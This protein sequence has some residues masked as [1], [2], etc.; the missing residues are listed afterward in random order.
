[1]RIGFFFCLF[2]TLLSIHAQERCGTVAPS[3]GTFENWISTKIADRN[4]NAKAPAAPLYQIPVVVHVFHKGEQV[5]T[6]V[7]LSDERIKEQIDSLTADFRRMNADAIN[8]PSEFLPVAADIEIEF[9]L[10]KQDPSGNPTN[11]IVR[12]QG[13]RDVY[14]AS[15]H[16]PLLRSESYWP[17]EHYLN[18]YVLDLQ[19]FIGY[20]S[21][22]LIDIDGITNDSDDYAF[23]GV[24]VD[25]E[26]FGVNLSTPT[27][28]S[29]GRT[30]THEVGHWLGL[31]HIWGDGNCAA[32]DFVDDTPLANTDNGDYTSPCTFPNPDDNLV[33]V[34]GEPEMF[35]NY[36]DYTDDICMNLFT[37]GQKTRMRTVMDNAINRI[38]LTTSPGLVGPAKFIDDLA[39]VD[40]ISPEYA[41]CGNSIIPSVR[42]ENHGSTDVTTYD[43]QLFLNGNPNGSAQT[44]TQTLTPQSSDTVIFSAKSISSTPTSIAFEITSVNGGTDTNSGNNTIARDI[45]FTRSV[46]L[47]FSENFEGT[48]KLL[49]PSGVSFPWEVTTAPKNSP[50][51]QAYLFKAFDNT[52]WFGEA[53]VFKTPIFDLTGLPSGD[54]LFSYAHANPTGAFYDGLMV[55]VSLDCGETF[56][57]II[58]S[59]FG[60]NLATAPELDSYFTPANQLEWVDTVLSIT[61]YRDIDGV[62]FAFVGING[63]S[64]NIYIDD[65]QVVETNLFENDIKPTDL[66]GPLI[67]CAEN[68]EL[69]LRI[70]NVGSQNITSFEV[71]YHINGDTSFANFD[72]LNIPS[73]DYS[74]VTINASNISEGDNNVGAEITLVNGVSDES[75]IENSIEIMLN[76]NVLEDEYPLSLDFESQDNWNL[77]SFGEKTLFKRSEISSNGVLKVNGFGVNEL[78]ISSWFISPKLNTGGLDSAGLYFRASYASRDGFNDRLQ[79][80][81]STDCGESYPTVLLDAHS[82]SLAVMTLNE[83]WIPMSDTDWKEYELDLSHSFFFDDNIRIAFVFTPGGGNDLF[84]DDI[85]IRGNS[86]PSY[87]DIAR[88]F[89][90]PAT[91]RFNVGFNLPQKEEVVVKL[92]DI[93]G[94]IVFEDLIENALNQILEY[95]APSQQG[96]YFLNIEGSQF[97]T[98][99]K[100]FINR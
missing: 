63:S 47:P 4:T 69:D 3:T 50:T 16:R 21:F 89:P 85:N 77:T 38:S 60:P 5:G 14:R 34:A 92:I 22:P 98:T 93:S 94:R 74:T 23:D 44:V 43:V 65:I 11:G 6:G 91:S 58:F 70:R 8:T 45:T 26:Y 56:P 20:A 57:D 88:V 67:T 27:F 83:K 82:D 71:K 1:M 46:N 39:A 90:N 42:I 68:S 53:T 72:G 37:Q 31:R 80:L 96:L 2:F 17:A 79:V 51:N 95:K 52:E 36:M 100:L 32:D 61:Q 48:H 29:F 62:Q 64:N 86:P 15:S 66:N 24:L 12:L 54:L 10:A 40:I 35:Q 84:I 55:K 13:S 59:S 25:F 76:R 33:C 7:N 9:V 73:K 97:N 75:I 41:Q 87:E 18:I 81:L 49:G 99:Q 30:L 28:D 78:G 19:T